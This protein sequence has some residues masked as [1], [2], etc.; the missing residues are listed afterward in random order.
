MN[1][2]GLIVPL[3]R[4]HYEAQI[5]YNFNVPTL[6]N[7]EWTVGLDYRDAKADTENHVY[8]RN[9]DNDDYMLYGAYAQAKF[10]LEPKL[11]LF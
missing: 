1:R 4:S 3:E 10:K 6:S 9:E 7:S 11:D 2:T 5:Q 8:G